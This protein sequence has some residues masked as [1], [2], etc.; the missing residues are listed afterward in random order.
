MTKYF[1][2]DATDTGRDKNSTV[3][4]SEGSDLRIERKAP[5]HF[6]GVSP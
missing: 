1:R 4:E 2:S 5:M 3:S 6:T